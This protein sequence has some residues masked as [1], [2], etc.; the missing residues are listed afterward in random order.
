MQDHIDR[1]L[2]VKVV[3]VRLGVVEEPWMGVDLAEMS[4][5]ARNPLSVEQAEDLRAAASSEEVGLWIA[6]AVIG[7][8]EELWA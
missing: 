6:L 2:A 1:M 5:L 4:V 8:S 7:K 3:M